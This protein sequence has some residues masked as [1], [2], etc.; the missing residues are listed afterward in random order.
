MPALIDIERAVADW[1]LSVMPAR[2]MVK[3]DDGD[4]GA[5]SGKS[6]VY[7]IQESDF[8]GRPRSSIGSTVQTVSGPSVLKVTLS[9]IGGD[10]MGD[11]IK[12]RLSLWA[13]QR[14][15]D[16]YRVAGLMSAGNAR[17][18]TA[19]E[20]STMQARADVEILVSVVLTFEPAPES[21]DSVV[22]TTPSTVITVT[23]GVDP[24]GC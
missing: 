23:R 24:H 20:L 1:L 8:I 16:L 3:R 14:T 17:D 11:A 10:A 19:L 6:I 18:L 5:P 2:T 9:F 13:T 22:I 7:G 21:I 15:S 12:T 4:M